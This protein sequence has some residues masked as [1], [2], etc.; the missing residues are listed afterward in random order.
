MNFSD[1]NRIFL[2]DEDK[3]YMHAKNALYDL[4]VRV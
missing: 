4:W 1:T 3:I 2:Y